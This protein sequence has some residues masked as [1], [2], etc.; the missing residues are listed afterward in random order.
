MNKYPLWKYLLIVIVLIV[1][2]LYALPNLYGEEP[3]VQ[4]A[5]ATRTGSIGESLEKRVIGM[6]EKAELA[7]T[8]Y[9]RDESRMVI[10][11][12][13]TEPQLK[14]RD[15]I[16]EELGR[17]YA[18]ALN[19]VPN[20]PA[21]LNQYTEVIVAGYEISVDIFPNSGHMHAIDSLLESVDLGTLQPG[22]YEYV[23]TLY[24][25]DGKGGG[26]Q[27]VTESFSVVPEPATLLLLAAGMLLATRRR[28][29]TT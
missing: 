8:R 23:V 21:W 12:A 27:S 14:A 1:G 5:P 28:R 2:T 29:L 15:L 3:A 10:R 7:Y 20:T 26:T 24:P 4:I 18:V 11:F 17:Q 6:L 16:A 22:Q 9:E 19:L 25:W 13:D